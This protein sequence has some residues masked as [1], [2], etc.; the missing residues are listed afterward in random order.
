VERSDTHHDRCDLD[1]VKFMAK[2]LSFLP[3]EELF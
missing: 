1:A 2:F 3:G